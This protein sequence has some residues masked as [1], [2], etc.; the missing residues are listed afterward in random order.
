V[1][2]GAFVLSVN[3]SGRQLRSDLPGHVA[4]AL[5]RHDVPA[6]M[7]TLELTE[8]VIL[9]P[10]EET[11]T[12]LA[13]LRALG[14]LLALDDFGTG[15]SSLT[16]LQR[17][18]FDTVK[19]D[20]S[21]VDGLTYQGQDRSIVGAILALGTSL[22]VHVVAEGVETRAQRDVLVALGCRYAQGYLF[23]RPLE[24]AQFAERMV[25]PVPWRSHLRV[26]GD[27]MP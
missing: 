17:T 27:T 11:T 12:A 7:L 10:S 2:G 20:R 26:V 23:D 6:R 21:F 19:I 24:P 3:L 18:R 4:R 15:W 5:R 25:Q 16:H 8:S 13:E 22:G 14:V 9:D 1:V